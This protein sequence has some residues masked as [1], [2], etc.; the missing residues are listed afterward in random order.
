MTPEDL[1]KLTAAGKA[2]PP[3]PP[4]EGVTPESLE[5]ATVARQPRPWWAN[6]SVI[7]GALAVATAV[8]CY[9]APPQYQV[10][11]QTLQAALHVAGVSP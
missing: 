9:F 1:E 6:R 3:P 4:Y 8:G 5:A 7:T 2:P 11:C 10:P